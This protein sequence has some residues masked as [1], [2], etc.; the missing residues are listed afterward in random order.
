MQNIYKFFR[1]RLVSKLILT[2]GLVFIISVSTWAYFNVRYQK[3]KVMQNIVAATDRLTTTIL[4]GTQYAMML[5]SRDD[6]NQ[7]IMN[8][9]RLS[10][11]KNIRIY[12]KAG[13]I[14]FSNQ[15]DEVDLATNIKAEAC[16][17]CHRSEPPL[18]ELA[19]NQ[20]TRIFNDPGGFRLLGIINPINNETGCASDSCHIHP[21]GKKILGALD[22]V[23]S[24]EQTDKEIVK[25]EKGI[26]GMACFVFLAT[27][28]I[29]FFFVM[30][31]VN[32]PVR[33][34]INRTQEI[35]RGDYSSTVQLTQKDEM[36]QLG[37]AIDKM[38]HE[39]AQKEIELNKQR[40]EY[41]LLFEQ[42]PCLITVQDKN[43][44]LLRYNKEFSDRFDPSPGITVIM[45][46]KEDQRNVKNVRWNG[47]LHPANRFP[48]RRRALT[49]TVPPNTGS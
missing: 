7:I 28:T 23:V 26:I 47:R 35:A 48:P 45:P 46:I 43:Y 10:E 21:E 6:I 41:M 36:G 39:I 37:R 24:L 5:N 30:R 9:G 18:A 13:E 3:K 2:V 8:I 42:V 4:L 1:Y 34:L 29:L 12:N 27:S 17:I 33:K 19:L 49:K 40:D 38:G 14:K 31:F 22:L 11:I 16:D 32:R 25:A 20:R 15:P 44:K